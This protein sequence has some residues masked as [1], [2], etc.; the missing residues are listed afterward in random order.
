VVAS[1]GGRTRFVLNADDPTIADLG[2]DAG[3]ERRD[4][5]VYFGVE[6]ASQALPELQHAFDAKHCRRCGGPYA[7]ERAFVGHLGHY[8]CPACGARRPAPDVAATAIELRGMDGSS[9]TVRT[10][11]GELEIELP[12]PGLYNVYNA[13]AAL[14]AALELGVPAERIGPSLTEMRAAF[15]RVET[16]DVGGHPLSILLVKNPA[17]ANEVLRTLRLEP[18][19][20]G[21]D[22][23]IALNDRIA[24]GR[25]VS[26]VWD[27]DFELLAGAVRRAVCAGTRAPEMALR[28]KYAGWPVDSIEVE[29]GI[30]RS[31]DRALS[32]ARGR[33]FALPTYTALLELRKLLAGRGLAKEFWR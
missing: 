33:V 32:G 29:A 12:L 3:G 15:G 4:G 1:R 26:W 21:L 30:E 16:I 2:R 20:D 8:S 14:A 25:D 13:L 11:A 9:V 17:G 28:L 10:P 7:Y 31:L 22:L 27:A 23:W 19:G 18:G 5:V 24:D 6:D